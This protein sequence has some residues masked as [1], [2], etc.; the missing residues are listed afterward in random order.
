MSNMA[1]TQTSVDKAK[2]RAA[3][4]LKA[5]FYGKDALEEVARE[6]GIWNWALVG[7]NP[8]K[9]PLA[10][11]GNGGVDEMRETVGRYP[12]SFGL[13][14]MA[15]GVGDARKT[16][17]CYIHAADDVDSGYFTSRQRG[18][19]MAME[20][21]MAKVIHDISSVALKVQINCKE[22]CTIEH[23]IG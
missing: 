9:L 12:H 22:D 4:G 11:G 10:G 3:R 15:F 19:A 20:P 1:I 6:E 17:F 13:L 18:Q 21:H 8:D 2:Q 14:R 7:P 16:K 23:V 5:F